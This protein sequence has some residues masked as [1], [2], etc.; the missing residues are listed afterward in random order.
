MIAWTL[1][2]LTT[3]RHG[4]RN[5]LCSVEVQSLR[6][7][8]GDMNRRHFVAAALVAALAGTF[9]TLAQSEPQVSDVMPSDVKWKD[10]PFPGV[11]TAVIS[12]D[13]TQPGIYVVRAKYAAGGK[14]MPHTHPDTRYDTVLSGE[15]YFGFAETFDTSKAKLYP[16]GAQI[17][18]PANTPH[19]AWVQS[20]EA[21]LQEV[22]VGPSGTAAYKK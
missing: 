17:T 2:A 14:A 7:Q 18:V 16:A 19:F 20:G 11:Q 3:Q 10:S 21:V 5:A 13:P 6:F 12:G 22:G 8:G 15:L 9:G 1:C 4:H